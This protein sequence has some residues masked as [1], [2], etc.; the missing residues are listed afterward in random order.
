MNKTTK[1]PKCGQPVKHRNPHVTAAVAAG[2]AP[3]LC[4]PCMREPRKPD[5]NRRELPY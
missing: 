4:T 3:P 2:H 1:C 5:D